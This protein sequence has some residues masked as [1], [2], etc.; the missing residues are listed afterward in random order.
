MTKVRENINKVTRAVS[1]AATSFTFIYFGVHD[2]N[3][4]YFCYFT[5]WGLF[6]TSLYFLFAILSYFSNTK[7]LQ[8]HQFLVMWAF[9]WPIT[10]AYWGYLFPVEG[11]STPLRS[12]ITHSM[13]LLLTIIEFAQ[14]QIVV[15]RKDFKLPLGLLLVYQLLVL[16]PYTLIFEPL[17]TGMTF[18][19]PLSYLLCT[20]ILVVAYAVLELLKFLKD[21]MNKPSHSDLKLELLA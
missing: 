1:L 4:K 11:T 9:N 16:V 6:L 7:S 8:Y 18:K 14:F 3:F 5:N 20:G 10:L 17:Y 13:P 21:L 19:S 15:R 2:K 12:S